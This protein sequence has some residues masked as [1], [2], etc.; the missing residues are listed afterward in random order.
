MSEASIVGAVNSG[1]NR[2]PSASTHSGREFHHENQAAR[3]GRVHG[4]PSALT[5]TSVSDVEITG[6]FSLDADGFLASAPDRE[7]QPVSVS[8]SFIARRG[9]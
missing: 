1:G 3:F 7:N 6:L 4:G 8:G 2:P 5:I 9:N